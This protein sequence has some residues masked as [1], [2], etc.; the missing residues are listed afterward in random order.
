MLNGVGSNA[1]GSKR[2]MICCDMC[3]DLDCIRLQLRFETMAKQTTAATQRK[4]PRPK[5]KS[6]Q[7]AI[8][9]KSNLLVERDRY[10]DRHPGYK[11]LVICP[12]CVINNLC[13]KA[14]TIISETDLSG[15]NHNLRPIF[16][17]IIII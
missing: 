12:S 13:K 1:V 2:S 10:L 3:T 8:Q 15:V 17:L 9:L 6:D 4:R 7:F 16:F 14:H 5:K 11:I